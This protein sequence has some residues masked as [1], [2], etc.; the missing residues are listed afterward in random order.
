MIVVM[1]KGKQGGEIGGVK[2]YCSWDGKYFSKGSSFG[3]RE[4][5]AWGRCLLRRSD[6]KSKDIKMSMSFTY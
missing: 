1:K 5:N 2:G 3:L 6:S 4:V